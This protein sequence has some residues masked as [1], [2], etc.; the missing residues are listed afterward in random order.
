MTVAN[1]RDKMQKRLGPA[2]TCS[3]CKCRFGLQVRGKVVERVDKVEFG[4]RKVVAWAC[5]DECAA[6]VYGRIGL[7]FDMETN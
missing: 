5:G 3:G 6:L 4:Y 2:K 1:W 7:E